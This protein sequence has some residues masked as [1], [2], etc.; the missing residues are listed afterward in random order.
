VGTEW[1]T[2]GEKRIDMCSV[3]LETLMIRDGLAVWKETTTEDVFDMVEYDGEEIMEVVIEA[4]VVN[5]LDVRPAAM[6]RMRRNE[7]S[8]FELSKK[9][10]VQGN[11]VIKPF[12]RGFFGFDYSGP[13]KVV[14]I[15]IF[16]MEVTPG[17]T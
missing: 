4:T 8:V 2:V 10:H 3:E 13:R 7:E 16:D 11:Y 9:I 17:P 15:K 12:E 6:A 14:K 5:V 1:A